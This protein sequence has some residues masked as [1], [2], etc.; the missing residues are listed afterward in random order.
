MPDS[1]RVSRQAA[2]SNVSPGSTRPAGRY[3]GCPSL[4]LVDQQEA[5]AA[6]DHDNREAP[7]WNRLPGHTCH[8]LN[9]A[10]ASVKTWRIF[11]W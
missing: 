1:S 5:V 2:A 4:R 10:S 11:V 9:Q 8:F 6:T 7:G 3:Q